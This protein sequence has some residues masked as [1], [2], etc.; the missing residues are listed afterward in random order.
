MEPGAARFGS[1]AWVGGATSPT[2][3]P[4]RRRCMECPGRRG[5][6]FGQRSDHR[7]PAND[8]HQMR[9]MRLRGSVLAL[10]AD[11]RPNQ[12][13]HEGRRRYE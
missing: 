5:I 12:R 2:I 4:T 7:D 9:A 1:E 10:G 6:V 13:P 11:E 8:S 3:S